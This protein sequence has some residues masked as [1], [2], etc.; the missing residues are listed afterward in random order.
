MRGAK[1]FIGKNS[2]LALGPLSH[3]ATD[4]GIRPQP[5]AHSGASGRHAETLRCQ[6]GLLDVAEIG[7]CELPEIKPAHRARDVAPISFSFTCENGSSR[8]VK[9]FR[10]NSGSTAART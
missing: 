7:H 4:T 2:G 9:S 6:H 10:G 5:G 8:L 1:R 3:L